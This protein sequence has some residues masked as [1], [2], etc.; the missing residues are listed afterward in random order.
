M[1]TTFRIGCGRKYRVP[2]LDAALRG[3]VAIW[4]KLLMHVLAEP[5]RGRDDDHELLRGPRLRNDLRG[6]ARV[7][8]D[9]R[10]GR[11]GAGV[12]RGRRR[13]VVQLREAGGRL[14]FGPDRPSQ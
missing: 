8:G 5:Q 6:A 1:I 3:R 10:R 9:Y 14:V 4:A 7:P 11:G 2:E 13:R 12:D